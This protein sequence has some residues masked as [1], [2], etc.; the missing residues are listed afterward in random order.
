MFYGSPSKIFSFFSPLTAQ[1]FFIGLVNF[2]QYKLQKYL[3]VQLHVHVQ[4]EIHEAAGDY[5][6]GR[7]IEVFFF[8]V[9]SNVIIT[10][11]P[12]VYERLVTM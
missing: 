7:G 3:V 9:M 1:E 5:S 6:G 11:H 4:Q 10:A 8:T 2:L 12:H